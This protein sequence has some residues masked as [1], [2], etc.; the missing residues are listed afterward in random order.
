MVFDLVDIAADAKR[1]GLSLLSLIPQLL[2]VETFVLAEQLSHSFDFLSRFD[3]PLSLIAAFLLANFRLNVLF[4][5]ILGVLD[6]G[7]DVDADDVEGDD[8]EVEDDSVVEED[9]GGSRIASS[10]IFSS[11]TARGSGA[12]SDAGSVLLGSF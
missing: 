5:F 3:A 1:F 11:G 9:G 6:L 7:D 8:D 2:L 4:F 12:F 10:R